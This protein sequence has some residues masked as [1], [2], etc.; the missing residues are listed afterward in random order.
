MTRRD[1]APLRGGDGRTIGAVG[2][3]TITFVVPTRSCS[4]SFPR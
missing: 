4:D 1:D 3:S 2:I